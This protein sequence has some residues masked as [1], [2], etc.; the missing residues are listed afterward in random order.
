[1]HEIKSV[2][3]YPGHPLPPAHFVYVDMFEGRKTVAEYLRAVSQN[4]HAVQPN[5]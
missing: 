3:Q 4:K 1:M 2:G 5:I